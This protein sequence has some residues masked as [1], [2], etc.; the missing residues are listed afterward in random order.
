MFLSTAEIVEEKRGR[1]RPKRTQHR[2][3]L[4]STAVGQCANRHCG[5]VL[6]PEPQDVPGGYI[7]V[8]HVNCGGYCPECLL[9][10]SAETSAIYGIDPAAR[11]KARR[12]LETIAETA[13]HKVKRNDDDA[14]EDDDPDEWIDF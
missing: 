7:I 1:G 2:T 14:D 9:A 4:P 12:I 8:W 10:L 6:F 11:D 13:S 3:Q 5:T